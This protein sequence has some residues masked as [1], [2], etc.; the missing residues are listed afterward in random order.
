MSSRLHGNALDGLAMSTDH[1][2]LLAVALDVDGLLDTDAAVAQLLPLRG[3]NGQAVR[4]LVMQPDEQLLA[5]DFRCRLAQRSV[6]ELIVGIEPRPGR[7]VLR[8]IGLEI[9]DTVARQRRDHEQLVEM[10]AR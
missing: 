6:G 5:G 3:L 4:Q 1:D 7:H 2:L 9:G 10:L 8:K